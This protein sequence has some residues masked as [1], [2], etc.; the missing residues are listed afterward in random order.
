M[1]ASP[2]PERLRHAGLRAACH[3]KA[4]DH[5]L[6]KPEKRFP[7]YCDP[8]ITSK[9]N[10]STP[11][12]RCASSSHLK[13][14]RSFTKPKIDRTIYKTRTWRLGVVPREVVNTGGR[15]KTSGRMGFTTTSILRTG[16]LRVPP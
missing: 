12:M 13:R 15:K 7:L 16:D 5:D 2:T 10:R 4:F 9:R 11:R 8:P 6:R 1:P 3:P 14:D